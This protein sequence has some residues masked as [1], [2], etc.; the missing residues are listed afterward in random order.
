MSSSYAAKH[1]SNA[2]VVP[3]V[4]AVPVV[5]GPSVVAE[6]VDPSVVSPVDVDA[7][8]VMLV[9]GGGVVVVVAVVDVEPV[10]PALVLPLSADPP[11]EAG[12][13]AERTSPTTS[14]LSKAERVMRRSI[15][16]NPTTPIPLERGE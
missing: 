10:S 9:L 4:P 12:H 5:L 8:A 6:V 1:W 15:A 11:V 16:A 14:A 7:D 13:P 2:P 3:V